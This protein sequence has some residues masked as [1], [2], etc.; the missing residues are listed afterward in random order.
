MGWKRKGWLIAAVVVSVVT[1][2]GGI[3]NLIENDPGPLYGKIVYLV[4][5]VLGAVLVVAGVA[6]R[7]QR[8]RSSSLLIAVGVTPG[9]PLAAFFW[10]PPVALLGVLAIGVFLTAV[11]D[12]SQLEPTA[13]Q[14]VGS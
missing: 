13:P 11:N 8:R 4:A 6:I 10:F 14:P 2:V 9:F 3:G 12:Y 1:V 5:A 7:R